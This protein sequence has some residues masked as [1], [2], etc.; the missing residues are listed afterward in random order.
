MLAVVERSL[1]TAQ[2]PILNNDYLIWTYFS[3]KA[4]PSFYEKAILK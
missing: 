4:M 2:R 3:K 1:N